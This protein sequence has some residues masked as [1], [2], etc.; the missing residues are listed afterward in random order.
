MMP[1]GLLSE[2]ESGEIVA[3][4]GAL[5]TLG[6]RAEDMGLRVGSRVQMLRGGASPVLVRVDESRIAIDRAAAMKISV[7]RDGP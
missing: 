2:G 3:V 6:S 5:G 7:R 4:R 1:L